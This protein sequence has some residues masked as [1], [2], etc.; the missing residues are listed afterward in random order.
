MNDSWFLVSY[1][2]LWVFVLMSFVLWFVV[3]RQIGVLHNRWGPRGALTTEDGPELGTEVPRFSVA[4][5]AGSDLSF[6]GPAPLT[7]AILT[8]P[9]CTACEDLA[10]ALGTLM[11]DPPEGVTSMVLVTDGD[12]E[13]AAELVRSHRLDPNRVG[14]A[15]TAGKLLDV[16]ATP[17]ALLIDGQGRLLK[18]GIVN[19][20]EQIEVLIA[21]GRSGGEAANQDET[22]QD[23]LEVV[24]IGVMTGDGRVTGGREQ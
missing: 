14:L 6:P 10:P 3:L 12:V 17:M 11:K 5:I 8:N 2:V 15:L 1:V 9:G 20:L 24:G 21:E 23:S 18:K 7:L 4:S 19:T 13:S 16:S 22:E